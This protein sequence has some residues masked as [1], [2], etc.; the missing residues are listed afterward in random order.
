MM[1]CLSDDIIKVLQE[2]YKLSGK[3]NGT[4][5]WD[6]TNK[7]NV[8]FQDLRHILNQMHKEKLITV[9]DGFHGKLIFLTNEQ[10]QHIQRN[11]VGNS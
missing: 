8:P 4:N 5:A 6:L 9:R 7:L 3:H 1:T 10:Y 11:N 2:R